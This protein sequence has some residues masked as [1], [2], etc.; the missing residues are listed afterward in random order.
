MAKKTRE[1]KL[2]ILKIGKDGEF[3]EVLREFIDNTIKKLD[4]EQ[5]D[6]LK[7]NR[8]KPASSFKTEMLLLEAKKQFMEDFKDYP[9]YIID[10]LS[11]EKPVLSNYD[12]FFHPKEL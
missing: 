3:W 11:E 10:L 9:D 4:D 6:F 8:N 12:P 5:Y 7:E 2:G 1:Q